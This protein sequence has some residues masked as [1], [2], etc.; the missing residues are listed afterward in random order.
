FGIQKPPP[1]FDVVPPRWAA[2]SKT[3]TDAPAC[4]AVNAA[5]KPAAPLPT[6]TTSASRFHT[7]SSLIVFIVT[8]DGRRSAL[9]VPV[10]GSEASDLGFARIQA[11]AGRLAQPVQCQDGQEQRAGGNEHQGGGLL[12]LVLARRD[13]VPE[14]RLRPGDPQAKEARRR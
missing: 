1:D 2:R 12:E 7:P 8:D 13:R 3:S 6:T 10:D 14:G 11:P 9:P 5:D 4:T